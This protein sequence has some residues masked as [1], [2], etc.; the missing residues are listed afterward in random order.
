LGCVNESFIA[1]ES[2]F[3]QYFFNQPKSD[4][5]LGDSLR[6]GTNDWKAAFHHF[7]TKPYTIT[8]KKAKAL[9]FGGMFRKRINHPG[10]PARQLVGFPASDRQL[11]GDVIEDHL[12]AVL[13]RVR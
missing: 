3:L 7:G 12:T 10:L 8:A 2:L 9:K 11:V 13:N 6:I 4:R 1:N 5:L